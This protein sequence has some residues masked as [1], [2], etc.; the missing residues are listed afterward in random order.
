M[1]ILKSFYQYYQRRNLHFEHLPEIS[2]NIFYF[3][4]FYLI[5]VSE[6]VF[7]GIELALVIR[8]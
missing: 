4:Y 6:A 8:N 7:D 5:N 2:V 1:I 3:E